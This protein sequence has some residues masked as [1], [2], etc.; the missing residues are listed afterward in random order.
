MRL[1]FRRA[2]G[3][4]PCKPP[5]Q[6]VLAFGIDIAIELGSIARR[7]DQRLTDTMASIE[8]SQ[9]MR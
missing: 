7:Q 1:D 4:M 9:G 8:L 5:V 2:N 6:A 3:A